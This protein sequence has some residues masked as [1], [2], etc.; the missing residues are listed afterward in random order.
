MKPITLMAAAGVAGLAAGLLIG[1]NTAGGGA[2]REQ[3]AAAQQGSG[4]AQQR[5]RPG[6]PA[7]PG[8]DLLSRLTNGRAVQS[9]T[10]K[11][12]GEIIRAN[13][14]TDRNEDPVAAARRNYQLQ[15]LLSK[16]PGDVLA[17]LSKDILS[18]E[19]IRGTEGWKVFGVWAKRDWKAALDWA[20]SEPGNSQWV[21]SALTALS[22][23]DPDLAAQLLSERIMSGKI[24]DRFGS[25]YSIGQAQAK[26]GKDAFMRFIDTLPSN[27]Q[28]NIISNSLREL[29]EADLISVVDEL[30]ARKGEGSIRDWSFNNAIAQ[31]MRTNPEKAREWVERIPEGEERAKL[32]ISL[33]ANLIG[34]GKSA[35]S[36]EMLKSAMAQ[37]PGKEKEYFKQV[38]NNSIYQNPEMLSELVKALP[39]GMEMTADDY[40]DARQYLG[41]GQSQSLVEIAKTIPNR[42]EQVKLLTE[43]FDQ[44]AQGFSQNRGGNRFNEVDF[45][46][47]ENRLAGLNLTGEG[48]EKVNASLAK[49]RQ[50]ALSPPEKE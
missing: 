43:A 25:I 17:E 29:P 30:Y 45:K 8:D 32:Q 35:E 7:S 49:A 37:S 33:A 4:G 40:K 50:A 46:I 47:L 15:L 44:A 28:S 14:N 9:L 36:V 21:G 23:T 41:W 24:S 27:Q 2:Q 6:R 39:P 18:D 11:D 48:A 34:S 20:E 13:I 22:A 19:K 38:M 3:V 42:E 26:M 10:A 16:L 31:L 1:K 5:D 12:V